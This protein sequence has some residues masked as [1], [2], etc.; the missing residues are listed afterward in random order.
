MRV[1]DAEKHLVHTLLLD[2]CMSSVQ[3]LFFPK[4]KMLCLSMA[5]LVVIVSGSVLTVNLGCRNSIKTRIKA[6]NPAI[7]VMGCPCHIVHNISEKACI[8][9]E[10]V[11]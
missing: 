10:K 6:V 8:A 5:Y 11:L 2:M 1:F 7:Y 4:C 9:F 3:R